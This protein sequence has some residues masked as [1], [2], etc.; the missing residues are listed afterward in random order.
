MKKQ[1]NKKL[2]L[3]KRLAK[4]AREMNLLNAYRAIIHDMG[5]VILE[6]L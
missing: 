1:R 6:E 5:L 3:L 2:E 4:N